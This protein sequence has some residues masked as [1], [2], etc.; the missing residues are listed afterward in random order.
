[1][2]RGTSLYRKP[3]V[4]LDERWTKIIIPRVSIVRWKSNQPPALISE[5][6]IIKTSEY[7]LWEWSVSF[8][9]FL[10][11]PGIPHESKKLIRSHNFNPLPPPQIAATNRVPTFGSSC[12]GF[13]LNDLFI[14]LYVRLETAPRFL[15]PCVC[16]FFFRLALSILS[17]MVWI[18]AA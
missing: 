13:S 16:A 7:P 2:R 18:L 1:M 15:Y 9:G 4:F 17:P 5:A 8:W 10:V 14:R 6:E 12:F 3:G 11:L